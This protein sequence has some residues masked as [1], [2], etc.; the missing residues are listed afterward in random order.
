MKLTQSLEDYLETI[1]RV[2]KEKSTVRV[3]NI[4]KSL[5]VKTSSVVSALKILSNKG[6]VNHEYYGYIELT[7]RGH[8]TARDIERRH[9]ILSMFLSDVLMIPEDISDKDA[10]TIEHHLSEKTVERLIMLM[11]F[12]TLCHKDKPIWL[13]NL[14]SY[15]D[16]K[17]TPE[18]CERCGGKV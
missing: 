6:L 8:K 2:S 1:L 13:S 16:T 10:C 11:D 4:A 15:I 14:H 3:K 17:K 5:K 9:R 7:E 12:I 18:C